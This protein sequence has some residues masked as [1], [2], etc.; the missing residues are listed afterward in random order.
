MNEQQA[1]ITGDTSDGYHTF[2]ELYEHR[3]ALFALLLEGMD[4]VYLPATVW[5]TWRNKEG[6]IWDGWFIAG[7]NTKHGQ[8]SYHLPAEWWDRLPNVPEIEQN[9]DYDGHSANDVLERL[10]L[11]LRG[12]V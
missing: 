7:M 1:I 5:K 8:V 3:H 6:E 4:E 12:T 2:N 9:A 11:L 10:R